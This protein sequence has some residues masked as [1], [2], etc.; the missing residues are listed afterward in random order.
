M[1]EHMNDVGDTGGVVGLAWQKATPSGRR[2]LP[3]TRSESR[4][5]GGELQKPVSDNALLTWFLFDEEE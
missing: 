5:V 2:L 4:R 3:G 1:V